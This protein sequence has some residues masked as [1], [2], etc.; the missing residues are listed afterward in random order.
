MQK[1]VNIIFVLLVCVLL[2]LCVNYFAQWIYVSKTV[3]LII[4]GITTVFFVLRIYFNTQMRNKQN[5]D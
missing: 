5:R 3:M 2:F 1:W 4:T